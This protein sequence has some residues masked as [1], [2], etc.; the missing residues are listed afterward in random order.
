MAGKVKAIFLIGI[1]LVYG[2]IFLPWRA[3]GDLISYITYGIRL[4]PRFE[5]NDGLLILILAL[6]LVFITLRPLEVSNSSILSL[7]FTVGIFLAS[8]VYL[9]NVISD[10]RQAGGMIGAPKVGVGLYMV[11]VGA[12]ILLITATT[13]FFRSSQTAA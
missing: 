10:G 7:L 11:N 5:D 3:E 2:G 4:Y 9:F 8:S 1:F 6:I 13:R 12:L